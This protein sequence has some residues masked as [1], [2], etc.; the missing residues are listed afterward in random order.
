MTDAEYIEILKQRMLKELIEEANHK[1]GFL[2]TQSTKQ[3]ALREY[4]NE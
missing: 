1:A 4:G 2:L 3:Y